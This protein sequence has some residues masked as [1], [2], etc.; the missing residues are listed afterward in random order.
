GGLH[1]DSASARS[2][3]RRS[4][5]WRKE[6]AP[7]Q[8]HGLPLSIA[9]LA[10]CRTLTRRR[11]SRCGRAPCSLALATPSASIGL[12]STT[13]DP[14]DVPR[15]RLAGRLRRA[16]LIADYRGVV[17]YHR[18]APDRGSFRPA[19]PRLA[20]VAVHLRPVH[21]CAIIDGARYRPL[22]FAMSDVEAKS[23]RGKGA[24]L[25]VVSSVQPAVRALPQ[26]RIPIIS[27]LL[28]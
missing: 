14:L 13:E 2:S 1:L 17:C 10:R 15:D 25:R 16:D 22:R 11:H 18:I 5:P 27:A 6:I 28:T 4:R 19:A 20:S 8:T 7:L 26:A 21:Y 3:T 24:G 9:G 23:E 12:T